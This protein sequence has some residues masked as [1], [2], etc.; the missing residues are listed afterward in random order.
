M[1]GDGI[2]DSVA[3]AGAD[4]GIAVAH[5]ADVAQLSA[6][7]NLLRDDLALI[8][9]IFVISQATI[10]NIKQNFA[11]AMVYNIIMLPLAMFSSISPALCGLAMSLSSVS[12]ALNAL[13]L[14]RIK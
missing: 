6:A 3:L 9:E 13:R 10:R 1:C 5:G 8:A 2:N 11:W 7:V 12:V 14:R 4:V